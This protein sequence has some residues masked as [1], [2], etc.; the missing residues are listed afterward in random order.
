VSVLKKKAYER[1]II[2]ILKSKLEKI[3]KNMHNIEA[4]LFEKFKSILND[5]KL[6]KAFSVQ[7]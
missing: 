4:K 3:L 7:Q 5:Q 6:H 2:C 1:L